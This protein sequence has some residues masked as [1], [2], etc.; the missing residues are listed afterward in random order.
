[1]FGLSAEPIGVC[2]L[3]PVEI[4]PPL[5]APVLEPMGAWPLLEFPLPVPVFPL[6][7]EVPSE[8][9]LVAGVDVRAKNQNHRSTT[10]KNRSRPP[11]IVYTICLFMI[12]YC[13]KSRL[14][15][16]PGSSVLKSIPFLEKL[17][18]I[19]VNTRVV[20]LVKD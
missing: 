8:P 3:F 6:S 1:M 11:S 4:S 16:F 7:C 18:A 15:V 19:V 2:V 10:T 13:G 14:Q 12:F 17:V 5:P 9:V 20:S